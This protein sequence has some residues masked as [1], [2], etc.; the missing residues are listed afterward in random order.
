MRG[1]RAWIPKGLKARLKINPKNIAALREPAYPKNEKLQYDEWL[2]KYHAMDRGNW[3][4]YEHQYR[5]EYSNYLTGKKPDLFA[6]FRHSKS[7]ENNQALAQKIVLA[8]RVS[9]NK[10]SVDAGAE[11]VYMLLHLIDRQVFSKLGAPERAMVF[12]E[13]SEITI[14]DY[15]LNAFHADAS[16]NDLMD[17][18]E[19]MMR[20]LKSRQSIYAQCKSLFGE[21]FPNNGTIIFALSFFVY[22]ALGHTDRND[23][24]DILTGRRDICGSDKSDFPEAAE[25]MAAACAVESIIDGLQLES[26]LKH[27]R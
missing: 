9:G 22:R 11:I 3:N 13:F 2:K 14:T 21:S 27:L 15:T 18:A 20:T 23:V 25:I 6:C 4:Y 7:K 1:S 17:K 16:Q 8:A 5:K 26:D 24:D 12:D 10:Y 19:Q